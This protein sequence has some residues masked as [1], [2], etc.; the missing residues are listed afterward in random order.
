[1]ESV[2]LIYPL[3]VRP[4][5]G[6]PEPIPTLPGV[7]RYSEAG[8]ADAAASAFEKGVPAV[9][10]FGLPRKK[11]ADGREA[12]SPA[13]AVVHALRS[14]RRK[15]PEMIL[16][17]DV[18]L[19]AYTAH[20][21]C[22]V[23]KGSDVDNDR[24][25]EALGRVALAHAEAGADV[26]APSA[27][28][29]YQVAGIRGALDEEGFT[30][31]AILGY[32]AKFASGLYGPFREAAESTPAFGDRRSYQLDDR[33]AREAQREIALTADEGADIVL[34]KPA[35]PCLD[36]LARARARLDVPLAA[37][38]VSGEYA[39][40]KAV[41]EQGWIRESDAALESLRSIRRAGADFIVTYF[42]PEVR[43][44]IRNGGA[45]P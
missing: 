3:F 14:I 13:S 40:I 38:Q 43:G 1:M 29:D 25:V 22:G 21:H 6:D 18:C 4:G 33:N 20:G 10:L 15:V 16:V 12:Y 28:M 42:A 24:T 41:A 9:L 31:V 45:A 34:V 7:F 32:G 19:C 11:T 35:Q 17:T 27:M 8:I 26:V 30:S 36:V 5:G 44:W 2:H 37:Y 39:M 23:L